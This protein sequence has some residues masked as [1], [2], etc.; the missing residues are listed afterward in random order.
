MG[1]QECRPMLKAP[2]SE[3]TTKASPL[4]SNENTIDMVPE[5]TNHD[6]ISRLRGSSS[7][8]I[9]A[10]RLIVTGNAISV[11]N[12]PRLERF[13]TT[14]VIR[15]THCSSAEGYEIW[16]ALPILLIGKSV[17]TVRPTDSQPPPGRGGLFF[18]NRWLRE[19]L[20]CSIVKLETFERYSL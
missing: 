4:G 5:V 1:F 11:A 18:P 12:N 16:G 6:P 2:F 13:I 20:L 3:K 14:R 19:V 10:R 8:W 15:L 17:R 9:S 7:V